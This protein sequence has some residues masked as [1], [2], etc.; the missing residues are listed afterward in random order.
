VARLLEVA[1]QARARLAPKLTIEPDRVHLLLLASGDAQYA[2]L[3][4]E[5]ENDPS[6]GSVSLA[7]ARAYYAGRGCDAD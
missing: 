6:D 2:E 4:G 5:P 1:E 3:S 7:L